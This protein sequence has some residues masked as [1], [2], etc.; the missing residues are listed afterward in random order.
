MDQE[1]SQQSVPPAKPAIEPVPPVEAT[2]QAEPKPALKPD[3]PPFA[4]VGIFAAV[5]TVVY[6]ALPAIFKAHY[7]FLFWSEGFMERAYGQGFL[8][9]HLQ[10]LIETPKPLWS[11][12]WLLGNTPDKLLLLVGL[13]TG[14]I[15]FLFPLVSWKLSRRALPGIIASLLLVFGFQS[16]LELMV[17]GS[18][19]IPYILLGLVFVLA[20]YSRRF[21]WATLAV[22]LIGLFRP[23][24]WFM[25]VFMLLYI[26]HQATSHK[27]QATSHKLKW[28]HF[29][30][31]L[32]PF[33][34]MYYDHRISGD[35]MY[36]Y[37][38][39]VA[40]AVLTGV[41]GTDFAHFWSV[42]VPDIIS[43]TGV[44]VLLY[45]LVGIVLRARNISR[46]AKG[47]K[48]LA[49][50]L[51]P[52]LATALVPLIGYWLLS[53]QGN[54]IIM[55]SFVFLSIGLLTLFALLLPYELFKHRPVANRGVVF[56]AIWLPLLL[57]GLVRLPIVGRDVQKELKVSESK[58]AAI[59]GLCAEVK[60]PV[61]D[62][63]QYRFILIPL[64]R[65]AVFENFLPDS[66]VPKLISYREVSLATVTTQM[67][68]AESLAP[69][70]PKGSPE[71]LKRLMSGEF[72]FVDFLPAMALWVP[73]D[74][75]HYID[76]FAFDDPDYFRKN[77]IDYGHYGFRVIGEALDSLGLIYDCRDLA[78]EQIR[79]LPQERDT[80]A[81]ENPDSSAGVR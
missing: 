35:W 1:E 6:L 4:V 77:Y 8:T 45:A 29:L 63:G 14:G 80:S 3:R 67:V 79:M 65:Y 31:L 61:A 13:M 30:P 12:F 17:Q 72:S 28:Y 21:G 11:L 58:M 71:F 26:A 53:L 23:D 48:A 25:A 57:V 37:K 18:W 36:T 78:P 9:G 69:E 76:A 54:I 51:D 46:E 66:I 43:S 59:E 16:V 52:L 32:A 7:E 22:G 34:W 2:P 55:G 62:L 68:T 40:Y 70:P 44:L 20:L 15:F 27:P 50:I 5:M 10:K 75:M 39:T 47:S 60:K 38:A 64:R 19:I 33:L 42:L 24:G 49:I 56:G 81:P 73:D 41:P 74:E